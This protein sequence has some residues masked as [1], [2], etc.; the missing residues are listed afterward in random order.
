MM[1]P[2]LTW[3]Q[4]NL[5]DI[6]KAKKLKVNTCKWVGKYKSHWNNISHAISILSPAHIQTFKTAKKLCTVNYSIMLFL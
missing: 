1:S 6:K 3:V 2:L 5:V 4:V